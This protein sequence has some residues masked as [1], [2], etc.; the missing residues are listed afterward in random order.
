M[1]PVRLRPAAHDQQTA[2]GQRDAR[3]QFL[4]LLVLELKVPRAAETDRGDDGMLAEFRL[5]VGVPAHTVPTGAIAVKQHAVEGHARGDFYGVLD[6]GEGRCP[7][8]RLVHNARIDVA[9]PRISVP[10]RQAG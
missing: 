4:A 10:R 2:M 8:H 7:G 6:L 3:L 9:G 1:Q 5:V